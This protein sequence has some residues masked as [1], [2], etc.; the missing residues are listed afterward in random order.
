MVSRPTDV[1]GLG[2]GMKWDMGWMHDTLQH[3]R[4]DPI[5]RKYHHGELTFR[6]VYAYSENFVLPLSHDEVVHG[7][8]SLLGKMPGDA[9]QRLANLRLLL[10]YQWTQPG[11]KLLFMG[12]ELG[13]P[14][15]WDHDAAVPW[16]LRDDQRHEG[17]V[18]WVRDL[19]ALYGRTAALH[20]LDVDPRG[21]EWIEASDA[22][23]GVLAYLR[24]G[25]DGEVVVVAIN[26]TPTPHE[27]YRLGL[28]S[29]GTWLEVLNGDAETY[30]GSGMGNLGRVRAERT[31]WHGRDHS[32]RIV[33][34][35]LAV[36]VLEPARTGRR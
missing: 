11:K 21:F 36:V 22:A 6:Q 15:E 31:P 29:G 7:K 35:P 25:P 2:F 33:L 34:P 12:G 17:V 26:L 20:G 28:P 19:N 1:G 3:L 23:A 10:G 32:A 18:R 13:Q 8:G 14:T 5:H 4:R 16:A 27:R 9:W 30:G 24:R